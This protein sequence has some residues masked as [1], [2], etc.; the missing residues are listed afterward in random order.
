MCPTITYLEKD[1]EINDGDG[2]RDEER[3]L[4]D[5]LWV[6][7]QNQC[8]GYGPTQTAVRHDEL[9]HPIQFVQSET[10]GQLR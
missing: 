1:G 4:L 3:L 2:G 9:L 7:K 5:L 10:V 8:E 6:D